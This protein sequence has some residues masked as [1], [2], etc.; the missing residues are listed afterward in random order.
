MTKVIERRMA[1]RRGLKFSVRKEL[2][3]W[4][5]NGERKIWGMMGDL[6]LADFI[7]EREHESSGPGDWRRYE[8]TLHRVDVKACLVFPILYMYLVSSCACSAPCFLSPPCG[9]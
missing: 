7:V 4:R 5:V 1:R 6:S 2:L 9:Q 3:A 8:D